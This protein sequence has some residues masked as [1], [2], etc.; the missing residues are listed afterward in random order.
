MS[1]L[2][3]QEA[4]VLFVVMYALTALVGMTVLGVGMFL[5][6][7]L[8]YYDK[9]LSGKVLTSR[10]EPD[11][12]EVRM[13]YTVDNVTTFQADIVTDGGVEQ[14]VPGDPISL[15]A[16]SVNPM[17]MMLDSAVYHPLLVGFAL[18]VG[19]CMSVVALALLYQ[20]YATTQAGGETSAA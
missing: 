8:M 11:K 1:R 18:L 7:R 19:S 14:Y 15:R 20:K 12:C 9:A 10:C 13:Q 17:D 4:M 16:S 3:Q 5:L 6:T 2:M